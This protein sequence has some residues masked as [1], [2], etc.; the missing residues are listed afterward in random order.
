[1]LR[2]PAVISGIV[3]G[4]P[5]LQGATFTGEGTSFALYSAHAERVELCLFDDESREQARVTLPERTH[6]VW[7]GFVPGVGPGQRYGYRV[8]D[9][10]PDCSCNDK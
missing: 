9:K 2:Y 6:N 1:M 3:P 5:S 4:D 8:H 7:H 10:R